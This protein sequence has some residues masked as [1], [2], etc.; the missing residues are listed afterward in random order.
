MTS[1][2][3]RF[4]STKKKCNDSKQTIAQNC[5]EITPDSVCTAKDNKENIEKLTDKEVYILPTHEI[6]DVDIM[7]IHRAIVNRFDELCKNKFLLEDYLVK[8]EK[9]ETIGKTA[10]VRVGAKHMARRL[11][12]LLNII[13][14]RN[15]EKYYLS[16]VKDLLVSYRENFQKPIVIDL[17][18][19]SNI[20]RKMCSRVH[21]PI[22]N[23]FL[24][25]AKNYIDIEIKYDTICYTKCELCPNQTEM[26]WIDENVYICVVCG[27]TKIVLLP[28]TNFKDTTR[29]NTTA[30]YYYV[31][32]TNLQ[33]AMRQYQGKQ[34]KTIPSKVYALVSEWMERNSMAVEDLTPQHLRTLFQQRRNDGYSAFYDDVTL[35]HS[36]VTGCPPPDITHLENEIYAKFEKLVP[37]F[38]ERRPTDRT[39]FPNVQYVLYQLLRLSNYECSIDEFSI[40]EDAERRRWHDDTW[41]IFCEALGWIFYSTV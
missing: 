39:S 22:I 5:N 18:N 8:L 32:K 15:G 38:Y 33:D 2:K 31:K 21:I 25:I 30:K 17:S 40:L 20:S 36:E 24:L 1:D 3:K 7:A 37:V 14:D 23:K 35:I 29:L 4:K 11:C 27:F 13:K 6:E 26:C 41:K 19:G 12:K 28:S 34:N 10:K 9:I 16:W